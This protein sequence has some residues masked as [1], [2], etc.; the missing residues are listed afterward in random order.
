MTTSLAYPVFVDYGIGID[1]TV[2]LGRYGWKDPNIT[3]SNFPTE[4][5]GTAVVVVRLVHFDRIASSKEVLR[6]F[7]RMRLRPAELHELLAFDR[8]HSDTHKKLPVI[9]LGSSWQK[10]DGFLVVPCLIEHGQWGLTLSLIFYEG[11]WKE[12]CWFAAVRE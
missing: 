1:N 3:S 10:P 8:K 6:E 2:R 9:G 11:D 5:K 12:V 4:R 7:K